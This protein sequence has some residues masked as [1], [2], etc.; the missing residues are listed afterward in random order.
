MFT[1]D[2]KNIKRFKQT[3]IVFYQVNIKNE[4]KI[5]KPSNSKQQ[6]CT[7]FNSNMQQD[8]NEPYIMKSNVTS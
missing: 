4:K 7:Y 5:T 3:I 2:R 8:I 6:I 1:K